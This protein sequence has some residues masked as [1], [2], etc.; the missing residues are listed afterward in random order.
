M[1]ESTLSG[2]LTNIQDEMSR[3]LGWSGDYSGDSS[4]RQAL[5]D[6]YIIS[7][8][9]QF[10]WPVPVNGRMHQ[11]SFLKPIA[12]IVLWPTMSETCQ[13]TTVT[14]S[15][16][17]VTSDD[18]DNLLFYTTMV[19]KSIVAEDDSSYTISAVASEGASACT[20]STDASADDD[21]EFTI[22][23]DGDYRLPDDFAQLEGSF[24]FDNGSGLCQMTLVGEAHIRK[25]RSDCESTGIPQLVAVQPLT[26]DNSTGQ[27]FQICVWPTP[28][29]AYTLTYRYS[30]LPD[31]LVNAS[32]EYP[33]GGAMH[34]ETIKESCLAAAEAAVMENQGIHKAL[35]MERLA[36]S[37]SADLQLNMP[38]RIGEPGLSNPYK[39]R[40]GT[41]RAVYDDTA[42]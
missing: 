41:L 29:T 34:F 36:T 6:R 2:T 27:R 35:F 23:A 16:D 25:R 22:T 1:A 20:V 14:A 4:A 17:T 13:V 21:T 12:S 5:M 38:D 39:P 24:R 3:Y 26:S 32:N 19:G 10:Y 7:G 31:A 8:L 9:R 37:I 28:S 30:I 40:R 15:G 42:P 18:T 11:W 33:Y